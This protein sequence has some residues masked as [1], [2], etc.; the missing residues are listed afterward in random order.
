MSRTPVF[1]KT[2]LEIHYYYIIILGFVSKMDLNQMQI[3]SEVHND[4]NAVNFAKFFTA[5][6]W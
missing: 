2:R 5:C 3:F 6:Y 1:F 4:G